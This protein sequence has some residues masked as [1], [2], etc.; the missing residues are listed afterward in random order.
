MINQFGAGVTRYYLT[1]AFAA[2]SLFFFA[3]KY[4]LKDVSIVDRFTATLMFPLVKA[5]SKISVPI[6]NYFQRKKS[7]KDLNLEVDKLNSRL[8]TLTNENSELKATLYYH[9]ETKELER[10][11]KRYKDYVCT[12]QIIL[13]QFTSANQHIFIDQGRR[14]GVEVDMIAV[15]KNSLVGRVD[16]VY[17]NYSRVVLV[18]DSSCK[19]AAVCSGTKLHGIYEGK[20]NLDFAELMHIDHLKK[21]KDE[22]V[23]MSSG[24]GLIYPF[25][26]S[27]GK[28]TNISAEGVNYKILVKPLFDLEKLNYCYLIRSKLN[29]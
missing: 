8:E 14:S 18:T 4:V 19:I 11:R 21:P 6:Q 5:Q 23:V 24:E 22:D 17:G 15:Y 16:M 26:F 28:I 27:L 13:R 1:I 29:D 10:F 20:G 3:S 2:A 7:V 25:G 9:N 12:A